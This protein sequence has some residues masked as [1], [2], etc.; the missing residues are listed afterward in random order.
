MTC[1]ITKPH[2]THNSLI[3]SDEGLTLE[4]SA[5]QSLFGG[6]FTLSSPLTNQI[7]IL[8]E[9]VFNTDCQPDHQVTVSLWLYWVCRWWSCKCW[10]L[11]SYKVSSKCMFSYYWWRLNTLD[12][13]MLNIFQ[14]NA[15]C[16]VKVPMTRKFLF[17]YWK[18]LS[19]WW[20]MAFIL[21]W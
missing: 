12:R 3:R 5:V 7:F 21:L 10:S 16:D 15:S 14:R 13:N 4:T 8:M 17:S 11:P 18:E 6:Q 2:T 1:N 20:R 19:K 9:C